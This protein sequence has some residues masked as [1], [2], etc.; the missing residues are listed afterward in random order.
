M[1]RCNVQ[2]DKEA[3]NTTKNR[4]TRQLGRNTAHVLPR[5]Y[6]GWTPD[7]HRVAALELKRL[8][9]LV[10]TCGNLSDSFVSIQAEVGGLLKQLWYHREGSQLQLVKVR[11]PRTCGSGHIIEAT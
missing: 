1:I 3:Q 9:K 2:Y 5:K 7:G 11:W 6:P 10:V 4:V 8:V